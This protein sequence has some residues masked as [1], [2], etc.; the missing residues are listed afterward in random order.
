M[1]QISCNCIAGPKLE[2]SVRTENNVITAFK[3]ISS[4]EGEKRN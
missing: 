2:K 3:L 4:A 1:N